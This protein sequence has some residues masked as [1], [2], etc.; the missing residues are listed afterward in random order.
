MISSFYWTL[1]SSSYW[2]SSFH[3]LQILIYKI[4]L[5]FYGDRSSS[6]PLTSLTGYFFCL[7]TAFV[8]GISRMIIFDWSND[9]GGRGSVPS[10][11]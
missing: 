3:N 10:E 6:P 9:S 5:T 1:I 11:W 2:T 8:I 4:F 7:F